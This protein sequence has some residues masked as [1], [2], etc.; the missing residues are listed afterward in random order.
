MSAT[1]LNDDQLYV[2]AR[3]HVRGLRM[4]YVHSLVYAAVMGMLI[5]INMTAGGEWWVQW[6]AAGWGLV[7][8]LHAI[9]THGGAG[10][11]GPDWEE[12]K[13]DELLG[14]SQG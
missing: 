10:L 1:E 12:R 8:V 5:F 2:A 9:F 4:L 7:V 13:I 14:R 3:Q 11:F 6:P